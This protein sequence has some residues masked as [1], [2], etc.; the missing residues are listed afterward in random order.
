MWG[1][2]AG[3]SFRHLAGGRWEGQF[4]PGTLRGLLSESPRAA[5]AHAVSPAAR[6]RP[7]PRPR[8][9]LP[10]A[11]APAT[12]PPPSLSA[13]PCCLPPASLNPA[14]AAC[15]REPARCPRPA[16][17]A[18]A[19]CFRAFPGL[20]GAWAPASSGPPPRRDPPPPAVSSPSSAAPLPCRYRGPTFTLLGAGPPLR[21][22]ARAPSQGPAPSL[23]RPRLGP[24][25]GLRW[26]GAIAGS[27]RWDFLSRGRWGGPAL[28]V[29]GGFALGAALAAPCACA[30]PRRPAGVGRGAR[31]HLLAR[32]ANTPLPG[33]APAPYA[34][35]SASPT[36]DSP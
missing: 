28:G 33:S 14:P 2:E 9:R 10:S 12:R 3:I 6:P 7:R 1:L 26:A 5:G 8:S 27:R 22:A 18:S 20:L 4:L 23:R 15:L 24:G 36:P 30:Q 29:R 21:A 31:W 35:S 16:S 13:C 11:S 19:P 25:R 17:C 34:S 32:P